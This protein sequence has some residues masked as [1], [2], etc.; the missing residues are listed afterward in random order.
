M[1]EENKDLEMLLLSVV[2]QA[3]CVI[4]CRESSTQDAAAKIF[5]LP[6]LQVTRLD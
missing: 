1:M 5:I 4:V 6:F 3:C 2:A